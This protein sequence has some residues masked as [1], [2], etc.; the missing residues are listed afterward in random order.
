MSN[1]FCAIETVKF[2]MKMYLLINTEA[3]RR[4]SCERV[5]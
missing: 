2:V 4:E 1:P 3:E 5:P